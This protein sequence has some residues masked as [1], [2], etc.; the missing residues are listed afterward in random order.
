MWSTVLEDSGPLSLAGFWAG[1]ILL[2]PS[3]RQ[4]KI[5][6]ARGNLV[7]LLSKTTVN[8]VIDAILLCMRRIIRT[9]LADKQ[10]S[11]Q[12]YSTQDIGAEDQA[13][14]FL[15]YVVN[16]E[17]KE[18]LFAVLKVNNSSGKGYYEILKNCFNDHSIDYKKNHLRI[19]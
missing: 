7:T 11:I 2:V 3:Y 17:I 15:R 12:V 9:K 1:A 14:R 5:S 16:S 4:S 19:I 6:K 18:R 8:K 10:F 13:T